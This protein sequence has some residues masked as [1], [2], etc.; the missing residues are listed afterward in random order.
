MCLRI[1]YES[2]FLTDAY[3]NTSGQVCWNA[4][5]YVVATWTREFNNGFEHSIKPIV[6][7]Q[8]TRNEIAFFVYTATKIVYKVVIAVSK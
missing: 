4:S 6:D 5:F 7:E 2:I 1:W 8:R 3:L